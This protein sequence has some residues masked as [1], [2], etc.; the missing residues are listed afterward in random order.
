[1]E[2]KFKLD[3]QT[4]ALRVA[5]E[6]QDGDVIN[7]GAGIPVLA[8]NYIPAGREVL[9][10][11]ENGVLGF[12]DMTPPGEGDFDLVSPGGQTVYERPG[13]SCFDHAESFT[14]IRGGHIDISVLGGFQ[15]SQ[16]GDLANWLVPERQIGTVGGAMDLAVGVKKLIVVMNHVTKSG[17]PRVLKQCTYP[18][19]A[20]ECVDL[21][22]TDVAV[23]EIKDREMILKEVAP[24]WTPEEVQSVTGATLTVSPDL[25][26]IALM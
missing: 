8:A 6:F 14:M 17:E 11:G 26:E 9:F 19:T 4:M 15:V 7:L 16:K 20:I 21:L 2:E 18:L 10:Q 23:I 13:M 22:V 1:M 5:R 24:G 25:Q 3:R 12:G